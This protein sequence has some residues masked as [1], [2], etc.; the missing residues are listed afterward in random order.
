MFGA[1]FWRVA[2]RG[3]RGAEQW[4]QIRAAGM[5]QQER[6]LILIVISAGLI[7]SRTRD[8]DLERSSLSASSSTT[9]VASPRLPLAIHAL[10][11]IV[12]RAKSAPPRASWILEGLYDLPPYSATAGSPSTPCSVSLAGLLPAPLLSHPSP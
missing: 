9:N 3:V 10:S 5:T 7:W 4:S 11:G 6:N 12:R 8:S 2:S 1:R